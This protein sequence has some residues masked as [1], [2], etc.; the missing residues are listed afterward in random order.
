MAQ[1]GQ[2]SI[3]KTCHPPEL[4]YKRPENHKTRV[5]DPQ[6]Q[7]DFA[8]IFLENPRILARFSRFFPHFLSFFIQ[9]FSF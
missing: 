3:H 6:F 1:A 7:P 8:R 9:N 2:S 4:A 5:A